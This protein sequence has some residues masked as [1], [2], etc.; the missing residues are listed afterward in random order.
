MKTPT[1]I[2]KIVTGSISTSLH[3]ESWLREVRLGFRGALTYHSEKLSTKEDYIKC[4]SKHHE[5]G[6]YGFISKEGM[7]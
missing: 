5:N 4:I 1:M 3:Q 7:Q 2:N 6:W